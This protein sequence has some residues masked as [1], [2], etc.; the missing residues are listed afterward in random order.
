MAAKPIDSK[1]TFCLECLE[2]VSKLTNNRKTMECFL[3][4][5]T[6]GVPFNDVAK[7]FQEN[8]LMKSLLDMKTEARTPSATSLEHNDFN[9]TNKTGM[10]HSR[11]KN[12][13]N[14][15]SSSIAR[16]KSMTKYQK[17]VLF[18][19]IVGIVCASIAIALIVIGNHYG[20]KQINFQFPITL[21]TTCLQIEGTSFLLLSMTG[22]L[23][24]QLSHFCRERV[25]VLV[26]A[27]KNFGLFLLHLEYFAFGF[28]FF[29][30]IILLIFG[31]IE[32]KVSI[33]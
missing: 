11:A 21:I 24:Y 26:R 18:I 5:R 16:T 30:S 23:V 9:S 13:R 22:P 31:F 15:K 19:W 6:Y 4:K 7:G 32:G 3:C 33:I 25:P 17:S 12:G 1:H 28:S 20:K 10:D 2:N 8:I 27:L 29:A 14:K